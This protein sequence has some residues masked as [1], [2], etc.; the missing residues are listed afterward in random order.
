MTNECPSTRRKFKGEWDAIQYYYHKILYWFYQRRDRTKALRFCARLERLLKQASP[1]HEAILG[2]ECWSLLWEVRGNLRKAIHYREHEIKLIKKLRQ[3]SV[4]T[5]GAAIVLKRYDPS[6]LGDRLD[7]LAILY[8]DAGE[9]DRAI[10]VLHESQRLCEEH[11]IRFDGKDLLRDYLAEKNW[12]NAAKGSP[13]IAKK[14]RK[15]A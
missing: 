6:D 13:R 1:T 11:G 14:G 5:P 2:E 9:L 12:A 10:S 8:H 4:G 3:R 15:L 7:L